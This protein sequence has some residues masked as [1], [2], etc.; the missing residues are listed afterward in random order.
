[1]DVVNLDLYYGDH[2]LMAAIPELSEKV[3]TMDLGDGLADRIK[4]SP[5]MSRL[6]DENGISADAAAAYLTEVTALAE[7]KCRCGRKYAGSSRPYGPLQRGLQ[8]PGK[9][10]GGADRGKD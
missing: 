10:Q 8:G 2:T 5:A 6:L 9:F 1:M 3:L 7:E 4:N